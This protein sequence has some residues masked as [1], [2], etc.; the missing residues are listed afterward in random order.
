MYYLMFKKNP[1]RATC[2]TTY[3]EEAI[4]ARCPVKSSAFSFVPEESEL[5]VCWSCYYW[6]IFFLDFESITN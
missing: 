5:T 4:G 3:D 6:I 1:F 2:T